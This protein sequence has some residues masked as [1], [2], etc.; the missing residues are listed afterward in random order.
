MQLY[1]ELLG[2]LQ[3]YFFVLG[4][5][6]SWCAIL[7]IDTIFG[8]SEIEKCDNSIGERTCSLAAV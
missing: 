1:N 7:L 8:E 6:Y 5:W 4:A 3:T 2:V